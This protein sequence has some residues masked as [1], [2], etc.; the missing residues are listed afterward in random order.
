M[1]GHTA[2]DI[3]RFWFEETEPALRFNGGDAFDAQIKQRFGDL[4]EQVSAGEC[5]SWRLG[6][7]RTTVAQGRLAE[8]IVLDQFR[9]NVY[10]NTP[11]AFSH[12]PMALA[13]AQEMIARGDD[14]SLPKD[15]RAFVYM[16]LMHSESLQVQNRCVELFARLGSEQGLDYAQRHQQIVERFLRFPHRNE[17]LGRQSTDEELAFLQEPGSSF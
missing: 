1:A 15:H 2:Q 4:I 6:E 12:D 7:Y 11:H 16:P 3:L 9:R 8:V 17:I 13:L 5:A 14:E 10:R